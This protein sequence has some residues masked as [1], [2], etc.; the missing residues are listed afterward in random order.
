MI[1]QGSLCYIPKFKEIGPLITEKNILRLL[2]IYGHGIHMCHVTN[3]ILKHFHLHVP[4]MQNLVKK[5][6]LFLR[7]TSF[8]FDM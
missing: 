7:K 3:I 1:S 6:E 5:V 8:N 4:Y 2:T